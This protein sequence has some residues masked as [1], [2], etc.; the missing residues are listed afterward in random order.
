MR[1]NELV[2]RELNKSTHSASF[3]VRESLTQSQS[4]KKVSFLSRPQPF[5]TQPDVWV[6]AWVTAREARSSAR[7]NQIGH[8]SNRPTRSYRTSTQ[9]HT[10]SIQVATDW[11]NFLIA[12]A[13]AKKLSLSLASAHALSRLLFCAHRADTH[14]T[15][16]KTHSHTQYVNY[17]KKQWL[18]KY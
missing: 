6:P 5:H 16:T 11:I 2:N 13:S 8:Q 9:T 4:K 12:R 7:A 18:R 14:S 1:K 15:H 17:M 3:C 10:G